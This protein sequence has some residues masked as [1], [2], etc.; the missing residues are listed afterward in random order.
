[1]VTPETIHFYNLKKYFPDQS[2]QQI[3]YLI[4]KKEALVLSTLV[5]QSTP[6]TTCTWPVTASEVFSK[7]KQYFCGYFDPKNIFVDNKK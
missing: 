6:A 5:S 2:I 7:L 3:F 1:M 4:A